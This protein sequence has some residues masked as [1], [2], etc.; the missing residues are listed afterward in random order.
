[1]E[2][3]GRTLRQHV[4][5][6]A[7][8]VRGRTGKGDENITFDETTAVSDE[9]RHDHV[10]RGGD[11]DKPGEQVGEAK[12]AH[13]CTPAAGSAEAGASSGTRPSVPISWV[14]PS[15]AV[16]NQPRTLS[17]GTSISRSAPSI[18]LWN[19]GAATAPP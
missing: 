4:R 10:Q 11:V 18:T 17:G 5:G 1:M 6:M 3:R 2:D 16:A 13:G 14:A 12:R 9:P 15:G 7:Q 8:S 19:T